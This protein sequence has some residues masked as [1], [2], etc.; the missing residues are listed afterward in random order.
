[1]VAGE[2]GCAD[3]FSKYEALAS[4]L[5]TSRQ[6]LG[7]LPYRK[8]DGFWYPEH[9]MAP[10]LAMRDA[11]AARPTDV[12]LATMPKSGTT[13]LKALVY[14]VVHRGRH[15][16]ADERHPLLASS[17][18]ELVPFLHSL[19]ES[20]SPSAPP[21]QL[22]EEMPSP[23]V[24]AVHSPFTALPAS[25]RESGCRVVYLCRDPKDA[26]VSL[27]HYLDE[28]KPEGSAMTPSAEAFDLFCDGVS[29]FGPV[30]DHM[31]EYWKESVARPGEVIFLRYEHLKEDA[32]GSVMRLA[33]FLGCPF[34]GEE[35]A[36]GVPEA[37]VAL[38][39]MDRMRSVEANRSGVHG[40]ASW[41]FKNSAF[42]RKGEVGDWKSHMTPEVAQRLDGIVEEKLRGSG[43]SLA[44]HR[45]SASRRFGSG[46]S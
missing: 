2:D 39:S 8:H 16:P 18:H 46:L 21:G 9:L 24:L 45:G 23:R 3:G 38:C 14:S 31:A 40:T 30:W 34:T 1:M 33:K 12:I 7:S 20:R 6:G 27:R 11:F 36:R 10:A 37:A 13:W 32:V 4:S 35:V 44:I 15:A 22:L 43:L 41:S 19:Y 5:P 26:F 42:F 29:P 28:I 25:V 17:P